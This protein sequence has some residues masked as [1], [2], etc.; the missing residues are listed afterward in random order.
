MF[1]SIVSDDVRL[2]ITTPGPYGHQLARRLGA[3]TT[4]GVLI[5]LATTARS[6]L[7][8]ASPFIYLGEAML[9][10]CLVD[11]VD[12]A[13]HR[14]VRL[15]VICTDESKDAFRDSL[16]RLYAN[17]AVHFYRPHPDLARS[18]LGSHAKILIADNNAAYVGSANFTDPGLTANLEMGVLVKG[19]L[20]HRLQAFWAHLIETGFLE[21]V[22]KGIGA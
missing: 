21:P 1:C 4:Y 14:G 20:A 11:A 3:R 18:K 13:V 7:L 10:G 17:S 15:D 19:S 16:P 2:V 6:H 22:M 12:H 8:L 9:A 5:E